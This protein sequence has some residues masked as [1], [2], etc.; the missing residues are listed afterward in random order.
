ME[1]CMDAGHVNEKALFY[2]SQVIFLPRGQDI[3]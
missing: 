1:I 3:N 2:M